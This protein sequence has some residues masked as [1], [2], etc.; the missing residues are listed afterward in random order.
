MKIALPFKILR[1]QKELIWELV[2][3]DVLDRYVGQL[4]G[5]LWS[6][7][8]PL[9]LMAL[10][11]FVFVVIF[12]TKVGDEYAYPRSYLVFILSGL[13]PWL[14]S[15]EAMS[16]SVSVIIQNSSLVKQIV[17]PIEVLPFKT[18]LGALP[19]ILVSL[20]IL[21]FIQLVLDGAIAWTWLLLP[22]VLS[23]FILAM[24]GISYALSAVGVYFRDLKDLVQLFVTANLF[25][26]P[27]FYIPDRIPQHLNWFFYINPFSYQVWVFQDILYYGRI[28]HPIAWII[29]LV[30]SVIIFY[31]G[32]SLF[33][34]FKGRF[35]EAL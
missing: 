20:L 4:L 35:G 30:G 29:Y 18:V 9:F 13:I 25:L 5:V 10:Y 6:I 32:Y 12:P 3:R 17:F 26:Q 28:E 27:I 23:A 31:V 1:A 21:L 22:F 14:T 15:Q 2:K 19:G 7:G 34:L 16:R 11:V 33:E 8:H 24:S